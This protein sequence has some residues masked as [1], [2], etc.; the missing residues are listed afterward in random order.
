MPR[1]RWQKKGDTVS[2]AGKIKGT[3]ISV[4]TD[5][6]SLVVNL[7]AAPAG[8]YDGKACE[9][10]KYCIPK[11]TIVTADRGYDD[12]KLRKF[13]WKRKI[14]PVIPRRQMNKKVR[15]RTPCKFVYQ[16]RWVVER[17]IGWLEKYRRLVVRYERYSEVWECFWFLGSTM[18]V[19]NHLTG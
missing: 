3:K 12:Q 19:L 16:M 5:E 10:L 2:R 17:G 11:R 8:C 18:I 14:K 1:L 13:F 9:S 6:N 15:R 7:E 4:V